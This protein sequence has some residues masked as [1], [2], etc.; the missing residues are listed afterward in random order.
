MSLEDVIARWLLA[1]PIPSWGLD[2]QAAATALR[3]T[4]RPLDAEEAGR[5]IAKSWAEPLARVIRE[6]R[7]MT[8]IDH[9]VAE[10]ADGFELTVTIS[11]RGQYWTTRPSLLNAGNW[12]EA[13]RA[14]ARQVSALRNV[15]GD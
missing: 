2:R 10:T 9:Q 12:D 4:G 13:E 1:N 15:L 7:G 8:E 6:E 11:R 5:R 14:A 3:L